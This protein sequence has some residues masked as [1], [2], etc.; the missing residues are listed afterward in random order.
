MGVSAFEALAAAEAAGVELILDGDGIFLETKTPPPP[1]DV[2]ALLKSVK[3]DLLRILECRAAAEAA[4]GSEMPTDCRPW[5]WVVAQDGLTR[6]LVEG[7]GDKAALM[8]WTPTELYRVPELWSQ[9]SLTGAAL[10][11]GDKKVIAV[12]EA[13][14]VVETQSGSRLTFRRI[15]R[16]HLA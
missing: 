2:V 7:W 1:A 5:R 15:G 12:T 6:F 3:P 8:G 10:L 9:I 4:L 13:S 11:I 16:E 14:I